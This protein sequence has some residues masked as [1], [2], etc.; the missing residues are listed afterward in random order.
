MGKIP[1]IRIKVMGHT[2][3]IGNG[4]RNLELSLERALTVRRYLH[5]A[6]VDSSRVKVEGL[7]GSKPYIRES[8]PLNRRVEVLITKNKGIV[9]QP[10]NEPNTPEVLNDP[11][12]PKKIK[13]VALIIGNSNYKSSSKLKN[14]TNDADLMEATL[15]Q[16][17]F[18][19]FTY[20]NIDHQKMMEAVKAFALE[21]NGADVVFFHFAGHGLQHEG[22]NYLLPTDI[23]LDNGPVDLQFEALNAEI[24]MQ[25]FEYTN[26]ESLNIFILDACR[27]NPY[28]SWARDTGGGLAELKPKNGTVIGYATS[29]G[30]I[31]FDGDGDNGVYTNE[32]CQQLLVNQRIEDVFMNTR[33]IVEEKT[34]GK[35]SP[36][37][38]FRLR[39]VYTLKK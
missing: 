1:S 3:F 14:P 10:V 39:S 32:L 11:A 2:D 36:W 19:T 7:G 16:L 38:L 24:I 9:K 5:K 20:K 4:K 35:Q 13:K 15:K 34:Q 37:E 25:I 31:A 28:T 33:I 6:G 26:K 12:P 18:E 21:L 29:P 30:A 17:K 22:K 27:S 8:S 23:S